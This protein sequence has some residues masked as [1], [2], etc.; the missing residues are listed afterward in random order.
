MDYQ[1][2]LY[3]EEEAKGGFSTGFKHYMEAQILY[4]YDRW[5][6]TYPVMRA[7]VRAKDPD[8]RGESGLDPPR[9]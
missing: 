3:K 1:L 6:L 9:P 2:K 4:N 8:V 5:L 7:N